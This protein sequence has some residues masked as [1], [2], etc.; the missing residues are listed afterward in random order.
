MCR[1]FAETVFISQQ[2]FANTAHA[3]AEWDKS[4]LDLKKLIQ[5]HRAA[6][7]VELQELHS[8]ALQMLICN[9][10]RFKTGC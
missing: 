4:M 6:D 1:E 8:Q 9:L 5:A 10:T 2:S 3:N 7:K